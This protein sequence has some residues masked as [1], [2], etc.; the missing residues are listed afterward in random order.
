M[1]LASPVFLIIGLANGQF[2]GWNISANSF[3]YVQH[4][5]VAVTAMTTCNI[6]NE[7]YIISG[8]QSGAV[9]VFKAPEVTLALQGQVQIDP[10]R[11]LNNTIT[12]LT[13]IQTPTTQGPIFAASDI[14]GQ[15][16]LI[17]GQGVSRTFGAH[18][19]L[20]D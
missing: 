14:A 6:A 3:D 13:V 18:V 1:Q 16:T 2:R 4:H 19:D 7:L 9:K 11:P 5:T 20:K 15:I 12:S 17:N 10:Q 8:D